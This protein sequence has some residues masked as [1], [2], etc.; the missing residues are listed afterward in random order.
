MTAIRGHQLA[1]VR[2]FNSLCVI[3]MLD[4]GARLLWKRLIR[5]VVAAPLE[6]IQGTPHGRLPE[7]FA[8]H[9]LT[10]TLQFR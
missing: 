5:W 2:L 6:A 4:G 9:Q 7:R 1:R 3:H 8:K 10:V